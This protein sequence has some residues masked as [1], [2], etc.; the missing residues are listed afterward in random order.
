MKIKWIWTGC[1]SLVA[2]V[3]VLLNVSAT[4]PA[5]ASTLADGTYTIPATLVKTTGNQPSTAASFFASTAQ[6][7]VTAGQ[8]QV[9]LAMQNNAEKYIKTVTV[10][11]QNAVSGAALVFTLDTAQTSVPVTFSLDTPMGAMTQSALIVLDW[12]GV[13]TQVPTPPAT[14]TQPTPSTTT[15]PAATVTPVVTTPAPT[16]VQ[17]VTQPR[18]TVKAVTNR[19]K[20]VTGLT[21]QGAKVVVKRH[22]TTLGTATANRAGKYTVKLAKSQPAKTKLTITATKAKITTTKTVTVRQAAVKQP[23]TKKKTKQAA[24]RPAKWTVKTPTGTWK[25]TGTK[26]YT[27]IWTFSQKTGL[28]QKVYRHGKAV[29]TRVA[30]ATYH[31]TPRTTT[32]WKVTYAPR[33]AKRQTLYLR[34]T[35]DKRFKV[36]NAKNHVVKTAAAPAPATT[37]TFNRR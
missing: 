28:T 31:V 20:T 18:L 17:T 34:F 37:W 7:T 24:S 26:G 21:S 36:V 25:A 5:Q 6:A 3:L 35:T 10:A 29:K 15:E 30:Y 22:G 13:P 14:V 33:H 9:N 32:F 2:T 8:A 19:T 23:K 27:Q 1:L 12:S 4:T 16:T 11:G